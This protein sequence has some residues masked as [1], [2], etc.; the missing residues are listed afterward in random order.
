M[1]VV[2]ED[3]IGKTI[4]LRATYRERSARGKVRLLSGGCNL[5]KVL[6]QGFDER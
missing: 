4:L 2:M 6:N 3:D 5:L 1:V